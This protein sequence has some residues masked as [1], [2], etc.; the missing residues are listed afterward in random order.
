MIV[1][2]EYKG[3]GMSLN[4]KNNR[5]DFENSDLRR[6]RLIIGG[7][8]ALFVVFAIVVI[9]IAIINSIPPTRIVLEYAPSSARVTV[10]GEEVHDK[11]LD[12]QPGTYKI[13]IEKFGFETYETTVSLESYRTENV[14]AVLEPSMS[15]TENW[16][17]KNLDDSTIADGQMS[18]TYDDETKAMAE[19]YPVVTK[20]PIKTSEFSIYYSDC[21]EGSCEIVIESE[22]GLFDK[23]LQYFSRYLDSELGRYNFIAINYGNQFQGER[24]GFGI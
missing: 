18:H 11:V 6:R 23:A 4:M 24:N 5:I 22:Q 15:L 12:L 17:Y 10:N 20:L 14:F 19:E 7:V 8:V 21:G 13:E 9:I 1:R 2:E 3:V 16:Y